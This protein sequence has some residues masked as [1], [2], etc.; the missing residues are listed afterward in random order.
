M[1]LL[2]PDVTRVDI[3]QFV[4]TRRYGFYKWRCREGRELRVQSQLTQSWSD[5]RLRAADSHGRSLPS[6][7]K[8]F[9]LEF[10]AFLIVFPHRLNADG[11][12]WL[13]SQLAMLRT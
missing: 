13:D 12:R 9:P 7:I 10:L 1:K 2:W 6:L 5:L 11:A 3:M 8:R 4:P